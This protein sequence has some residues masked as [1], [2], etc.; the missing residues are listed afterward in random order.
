VSIDPVLYDAVIFDNDGVL[1][2]RTSYDVLHEATWAAFEA[3]GV[4][5]PD[6]DDV[7]AMVVDVSPEEVREVCDHYEL[8]PEQFWQQRDQLSSE[9]QQTEACA[10]R[11]T[12]YEDLSALDQLS[13]PIGVVSSNQQATVDFL[14]T[15]F[16]LSSY[17]SVALGREPTVAAL[18]QQKPDPHYLTKAVDALDAE[19]ALFVGDN[20]SDIAAAANAG[21]DSA[22]IRRPHRRSHDPSPEPTHI[23]EDLHDIVGLLRSTTAQS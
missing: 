1:V 16:G 3:V 23:V 7:E 15:Y 2:S 4:S 13:V 22:F 20:D 21:M 19:S 6:P 14:L 8:D 18:D 12:P 17:V 11:K 9:R 10:G 5:D